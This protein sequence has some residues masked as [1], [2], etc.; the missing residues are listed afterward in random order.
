M[1]PETDVDDLLKS[2]GRWGNFQKFQLAFNLLGFWPAAFHLLSIVFIGYRPDFECK[3]PENVYNNETFYP[4]SDVSYTVGQCDVKVFR[5]MTNSTSD[6]TISCSEYSYPFPTDRSFV[7]EWDLVCDRSALAEFT[8]TLM[9]I[10]QAI[11]A[12]VCTSLSDRFGRKNLCLVSHILLLAFG[13]AVSFS[14]NFIVFA[15][16]RFFTGI[17]QQGFAMSLTVLNLEILPMESRYLAEVYGLL[18]WTTG[19]AMITPFGYFLRHYSWRYTQLALTLVSSYALIQYWLQEESIRWLLINNKL[20]EAERIVRKAARWNKVKYDDVMKRVTQMK[21]E[22]KSISENETDLIRKD[23]TLQNK[24]VYADTSFTKPYSSL[25]K[26]EA[27]LIYKDTTNT[28]SS[29]LT[30]QLDSKVK[31][32]S[33]KGNAFAVEHLNATHIFREKRIFINSLILWI[34]WVTNSLTYY[35]LTLTSTSLAGNRFLNYLL[36]GL[37]EYPAALLQFLM[38]KRTGR[39]TTCFVFHIVAGSSLAVAT[40]FRYFSATKVFTFVGKMSITGSFSTIFLYTPELYPTNLRNVGIGFS[41][42]ASRAGGMI[43]P[44]AGTMAMYVAWGPGAVFGIMCFIV[45]FLCLYLPETRGHELPQ[46]IGE[47]KQWYKQ[48]SGRGKKRNIKEKL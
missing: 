30:T 33:T 25:N 47:L 20:K 36:S 17:F 9:M 2:L 10:G 5:N 42:A 34:T 12:T 11:G 13:I 28:L 4:S 24:T 18:I 16:L 41:S 14:P 27:L 39:K 35:A 43:A 45:S 21:E 1:D 8:Q 3:V 15:V 26:D 19:V 6:S 44:F 40:V 32:D 37:V 23:E 7:T 48:H 29:Q 31:E 22:K 38:L 46:T